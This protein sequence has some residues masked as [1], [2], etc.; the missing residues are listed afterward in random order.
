M[1]NVLKP[2]F[3][4]QPTIDISKHASQRAQQRGVTRES[5]ELAAKF[6]KPKRAV[7]GAVRRTM[8]RKS[9]SLTIG[10]GYPAAEVSASVGTVVMTVDINDEDRLV[11]TVMPTEK[12]GFTRGRRRKP[13]YSRN[14]LK[15]IRPLNQIWCDVSAKSG[16]TAETFRLFISFDI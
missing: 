14:L 5:V 13:K 10:Q 7:G 3:Q 11:I 9:V 12:N 1:S 16:T 15:N 2:C 6:G 4:W 8:D